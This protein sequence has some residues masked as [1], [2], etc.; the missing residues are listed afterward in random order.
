MDYAM[1]R[2]DTMQHEDRQQSGA[3]GDQSAGRQGC[4]QAGCVGAMPA[5]MIA[6]M[7]ALA[8]RGVREL[9]MPATSDR[10]WHALAVRRQGA[11]GT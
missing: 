5:I 7:N 4:R 3:D 1:P 9:D 11:G 6:V 10:V 8:E 2:A